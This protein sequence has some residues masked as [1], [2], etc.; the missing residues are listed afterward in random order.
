[1]F[2][3]AAWHRHTC[4]APSRIGV[5][6]RE[7]PNRQLRYFGKAEDTADRHGRGATRRECP[8][9]LALPPSPKLGLDIAGREAAR[10]T[11]VTAGQHRAPDLRPLHLKPARVAGRHVP[12]RQSRSGS[13]RAAPSTHSSRCSSPQPRSMGNESEPPDSSGPAVPEL[14]VRHPVVSR[15]ASLLPHLHIVRFVC[16]VFHFNNKRFDCFFS[17]R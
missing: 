13:V 4:S 11:M 15:P 17:W 9:R 2:S 3:T 16:V 10:V 7:R 12:S 1:M 5:P 6:R 8:D 14:T